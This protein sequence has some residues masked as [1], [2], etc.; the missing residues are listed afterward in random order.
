MQNYLR[1]AAMARERGL[2]DTGFGVQCLKVDHQLHCEIY[3]TPT[4]TCEPTITV[5]R[6]AGDVFMSIDGIV[7]QRY[8]G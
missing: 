1:L 6:D 2:F 3:T 5:E 8:E 7:R 4:C